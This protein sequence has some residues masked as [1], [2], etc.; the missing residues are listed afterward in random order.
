[1]SQTIKFTDHRNHV[2]SLTKVERGKFLI[3]ITS[4]SS[5]QVQVELSDDE[6]E[7]IKDTLLTDSLNYFIIRDDAP[8]LTLGLTDTTINGTLIERSYFL[9][10][11]SVNPLSSADFTFGS[12]TKDEG[13]KIA[14][15][16][17]ER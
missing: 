8:V 16:L 5:P 6:V 15:F 12:S 17:R 3:K 2:L 10:L 4:G 7:K 11:L 9:V 14:Q 1:M 13:Q